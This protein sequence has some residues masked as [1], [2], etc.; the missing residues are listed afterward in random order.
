MPA[1]AAR[2]TLPDHP[3]DARTVAKLTR[4]QR[5]LR[6]PR[7]VRGR[8]W[9]V[10]DLHGHRT[11]LEAELERLAFDPA[12]DRL[13]SVGDLVD[14]GPDSYD[15]AA[16][17]REPWFFAVLGNHEL[18]L[19][20]HL[21]LYSSRMHS[22][23]AH[24]CGSGQ[25]VARLLDREPLGLHRLAGQIAKLPLALHV[26]DE[27]PF[28]VTHADLTSF[29]PRPKAL[30]S[31]EPVSLA[32]ADAVTAS[33]ENIAQ[34]QAGQWQDLHF[35]SRTVRLSP[36]PM[37]PWPLTYVGHSPLR[38]VSVHRSHVYI[39]QGMC[40]RAAQ[41]EGEQRA[42]TVLEHR[43]FAHWLRGA[44]TARQDTTTDAVRRVA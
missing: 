9:V 19:L 10:G 41:R 3:N 26:D 44:H 17:V 43:A 37:G 13:F 40:E 35:G 1:A 20:N 15:T 42:P 8:D 14:K 36:L 2:E 29:G 6:L 23:K 24:A 31:G 7:N 33:R 39:D 11:L 4:I 32:R 21:G 12:R 28:I 16:L 25:W 22:R 5:C 18:M 30:L 34:A 38:E 27:I